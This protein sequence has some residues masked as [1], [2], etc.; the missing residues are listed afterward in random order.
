MDSYRSTRPYISNFVWRRAS[1]SSRLV[2]A[3]CSEDN[4]NLSNRNASLRLKFLWVYCPTFSWLMVVQDFLSPKNPSDVQTGRGNISQCHRVFDSV[5]EGRGIHEYYRLPQSG[6]SLTVEAKT[7]HVSSFFLFK[8]HLS[9][10]SGQAMFSMGDHPCST[11]VG[12]YSADGD[13]VDQLRAL[14]S[15]PHICAYAC[16]VQCLCVC[17]FWI[18]VHRDTVHSTCLIIYRSLDLRDD[19]TWDY[20]HTSYHTEMAESSNS[21]AVHMFYHAPCHPKPIMS[22]LH[23]VPTICKFPWG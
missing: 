14:V 21:F 2:H 23:G 6:N 1:T 15:F 10:P 16:H 4:W 7:P 22:G 13:L 3:L 8:S 18:L 19:I 20:M 9:L 5:R 11:F 12:W 17:F